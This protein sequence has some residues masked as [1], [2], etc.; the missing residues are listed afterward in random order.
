M[1]GVWSGLFDDVLFLGDGEGWWFFL[2]D[3]F[4]GWL[5]V[6]LWFLLGFGWAV[7]V[8]LYAFVADLL[9]LWSLVDGVIVGEAFFVGCQG[10]ECE[11]VCEIGCSFCRD[12][13]GFRNDNR[14]WLFFDEALKIA[15]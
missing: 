11:V 1:W 6:Y 15:R 12:F 10:V 4:N 7:C 9:R 14:N 2:M 3:G 13:W 8:G 5:I